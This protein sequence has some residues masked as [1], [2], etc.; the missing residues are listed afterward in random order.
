MFKRS[1]IADKLRMGEGL[2]KK[3]E[4]RKNVYM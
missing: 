4:R 3:K 2:N 1:W